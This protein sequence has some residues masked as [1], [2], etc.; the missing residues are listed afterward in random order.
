MHKNPVF[1]QHGFF[2][3]KWPGKDLGLTTMDFTKHET[4]EADAIL[5]TG[6]RVT[7]HEAMTE[8]YID[9]VA[10]GIR[11]VAQHYTA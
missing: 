2:A 8:Q 7:I 6:I 5:Q 9:E 3:G 4:P 11:K 1:Q 10:T